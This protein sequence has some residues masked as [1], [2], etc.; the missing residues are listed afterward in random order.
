M[1]FHHARDPQEPDPFNLLL[2]TRLCYLF[3]NE[4]NW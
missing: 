1:L 2:L 3:Y 4:A